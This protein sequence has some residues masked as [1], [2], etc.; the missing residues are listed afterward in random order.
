[1]RQ[2]LDPVTL[3]S[4]VDLDYRASQEGASSQSVA[5]AFAHCG[6]T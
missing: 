6:S 3:A 4:Q 2:L 5:K 1:M